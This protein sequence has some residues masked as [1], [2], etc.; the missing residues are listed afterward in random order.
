M[1]IKS[2]L[3]IALV[4]FSLTVIAQAKQGKI[5]YDAYFT[6][7]NP[8]F[9][10]F[11]EKME[12]ST[13]E[14]TFMD[15]KIRS[16][17][18]AGDAMTN[19]TIMHRDND[20]TLILMDG[21]M[22]RIAMKITDADMDEDR[23]LA[24]ENREVQLIDET[25]EIMGY[26]CKKA[27]ITISGAEESIVWYTEEIVPNYRAGEYLL[28]EIPGVPLEFSGKWWNFDIKAV[29]FDFKEKLKKTDEIFSTKIPEGYTLRTAEEMKQTG[30]R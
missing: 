25:K 11:A 10:A 16:D 26:T 18:F 1:K 20:T 7:E 22:G 2:I 23:R 30:G 14:L 29:A 3:S 4:M 17:L 15:G 28:K 5:S 19:N 24:Y 9:A 27:I 12:G 13:L 8:N 21:M 6:S